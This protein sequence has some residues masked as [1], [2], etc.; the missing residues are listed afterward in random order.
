[1]AAGARAIAITRRRKLHQ[2]SGAA[3]TA[4]CGW[5]AAAV[6]TSRPALRV[7]GASVAPII[8][9]I[10]WHST[11]S[12]VSHVSPARRKGPRPRFSGNP[13]AAAPAAQKPEPGCRASFR[14][15]L[16][17]YPIF[18]NGH[19]GPEDH[20]NSRVT[21]FFLDNVG[22]SLSSWNVPIPLDRPTLRFQGLRNGCGARAIFARVAEKNVAHVSEFI[23]TQ[24]SR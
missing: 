16:L 17:N 5:L 8:E 9:A 18:R 12:A 7:R 6:L 23:V 20:H 10:F 3:S 14:L 4:G 1:M 13:A 21:D 22:E 2:L 24:L 15:R 19:L 11:R